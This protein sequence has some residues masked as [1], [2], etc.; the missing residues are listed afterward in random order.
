MDERVVPLD[1]ADSNYKLAWDGF[2]S[3]VVST[4]VLINFLSARYFLP[5]I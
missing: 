3:K 4:K 1:S 5:K 2:L